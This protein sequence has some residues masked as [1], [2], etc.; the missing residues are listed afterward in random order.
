[1]VDPLLFKFLRQDDSLIAYAL[2]YIAN[3]YGRHSC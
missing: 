3:D 2:A 1:M